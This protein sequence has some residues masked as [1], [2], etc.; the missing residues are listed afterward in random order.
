[1]LGE[2]K[3]ELYS[4]S[5]TKPDPSLRLKPKRALPSGS[6]S[7]EIE[8]EAWPPCL[9][10]LWMPRFQDTLLVSKRRQCRCDG[11]HRV[12]SVRR[13]ASAQQANLVIGRD[14]ESGREAIAEN[15]AHVRLK[16]E[17]QHRE[18]PVL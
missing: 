17:Y 11:E 14:L 3:P 1:M 9:P 16:R 12:P 15:S 5:G 6:Q 4:A 2:A 8:P 7:T 18:D 10:P 13:H